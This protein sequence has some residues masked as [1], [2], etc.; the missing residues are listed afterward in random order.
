MKAIHA[1]LLTFALARVSAVDEKHPEHDLT[2]FSCDLAPTIIADEGIA[3]KYHGYL[4]CR[5]T[6][7][8]GSIRTFFEDSSFTCETVSE[9]YL[10][11]AA[12]GVGGFPTFPYVKCLGANAIPPEQDNSSLWNRPAVPVLND[13]LV[14][15]APINSSVIPAPVDAVISN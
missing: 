15:P 6:G 13:S 3:D 5:W 11:N 4:Y 2:H 7:D 12:Y 10:A 14:T 8:S 9:T 1:F